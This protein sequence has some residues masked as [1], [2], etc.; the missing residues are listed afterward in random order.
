MNAILLNGR[1]ITETPLVNLTPHDV[2][3][4][5]TGGRL[6]LSAASEAARLVSVKADARVIFACGLPITVTRDIEVEPRGLP[7]ETESR[8]FVVSRAVAERY[9]FRRDLVF[10]SALE[11]DRITGGVVGCHGLSRIA[12]W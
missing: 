9:P 7:A 10:P 4:I 8:L 12:D 6:H 3:V 1:P 5:T 2:V 11:R